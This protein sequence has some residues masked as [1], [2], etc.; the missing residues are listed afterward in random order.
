MWI[1][2]KFSFKDHQFYVYFHSK[3]S[4]FKFN[5]KKTITGSGEVIIK[6]CSTDPNIAYW[7]CDD[8]SGKEREN[9]KIQKDKCTA[10]PD[11]CETVRILMISNT[12]IIDP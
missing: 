8:L 11:G 4:N 10:P 12:V 3:T 6:A 7:K 1:I 2:N 5:K 9:C